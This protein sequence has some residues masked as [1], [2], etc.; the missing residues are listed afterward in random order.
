MKK[1][2]LK[3]IVLLLAS[4]PAVAQTVS[5]RVTN[6][7]DGVALPGVSGLVKGTTS[8]TTTDVDGKYTIASTDQNAVLVFS[9]IGYATQEVAL[10]GRSAVDIS[11]KEDVTQLGEV[12]VTALGIAKDV[13]ALGYSVSKVD[14]GLMTQARELNVANSL[15]GRVAG[16][17]VSAVSGGAGSSSNVIIR[18]GAS[19]FGSNQP[20]YVINGV[21]IDNSN[22]GSSGMWGGADLGDGIG[23]LNPDDIDLYADFIVGCRDKK[24]SLDV[25]ALS[26]VL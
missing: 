17:N 1:C 19:M 23:N 20:L 12:V 9:F 2:L 8:G 24:V 13:K 22:R 14:G 6:S 4:A 26:W 11:M 5:G 10:N 7:A 21:P 3:L 15:V 18:G 16:V 25:D